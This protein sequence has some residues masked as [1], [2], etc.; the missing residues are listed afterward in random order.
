[1]RIKHLALLLLVVQ[2]FVLAQV[3]RVPAPLHL[4]DFQHQLCTHQS[5]LLGASHQTPCIQICCACGCFRPA[6]VLYFRGW[7]GS[8]HGS[9]WC[10]WHNLRRTTDC[11][12]HVQCAISL[13]AWSTS[14][15]VS[16]R[17]AVVQGAATDHS[18]ADITDK[19]P[20]LL[21]AASRRTLQDTT[22]P[23]DGFGPEA[24][25][26]N[27]DPPVFPRNNQQIDDGESEGSGFAETDLGDTFFGWFV[28]VG[29]AWCIYRGCKP[30]GCCRPHS[31][32]QQAQPQP[33]A[34]PMGTHQ[35]AQAHPGQQW[36]QAIDPR[37][38]LAVAHVHIAQQAPV[39]ST[40]VTRPNIQA[41]VQPNTHTHT[42][43]HTHTDC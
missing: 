21:A 15:S 2:G 7:L 32:S 26:G 20:K 38:G 11:I 3:C 28:L 29:V 13:L 41:K 6:V 34:G 17:F 16:M 4:R 39:E 1:M 40:R 19:Q 12:T 24:S 33:T 31:S 18:L 43:T 22:S 30:G 8:A 27:D 23:S 42:H 37:A 25:P 35:M 36:T 14:F 9:T 10:R 5:M